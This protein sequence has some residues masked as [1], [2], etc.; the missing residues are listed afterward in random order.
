LIVDWTISRPLAFSIFWMS[1]SATWISLSGLAQRAGTRDYLDVLAGEVRDLAREA[2]RVVERAG[3]H[4]LGRDHTVG[5]RDPVVVLA[6]RWRLVDD[7]CTIGI[8]YVCVVQD[9]E[10]AVPVLY[11][12]LNKRSWDPYDAAYLV[13][14]VVKHGH[15]FPPLH[16][17]ALVLAD[18]LELG[19]LRVLVQ[20]AE[21]VFVDDE[22]AIPLLIVD[23]DVGKVRMHAER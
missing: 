15:I 14:E 20:R 9:T 22:V 18:L 16:L 17:R 7:A 8:R 10:R 6:E 2:P 12:A 13:L 21:E 4:L 5:D 19:L 3:R 1:L 23:L 11:T